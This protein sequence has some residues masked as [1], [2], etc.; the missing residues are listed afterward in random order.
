[1]PPLQKVPGSE[2]EPSGR[3]RSPNFPAISLPEA[4]KRVKAIYDKDGRG[5]VSAGVVL[6]HL[7]YGKKLSGSAGRMISALRQYGLLDDLADN[8]HRV[9]EAAFHILTLSDDSD[10][11]RAALTRCGQKPPVFRDVLAAYPERLPSDSALRDHLITEKK[12]NPASV[13]VFIRA[14]RATVEFACLDPGAHNVPAESPRGEAM[15]ESAR[16]FDPSKDGL[17]QVITQHGAT[18]P[19]ILNLMPSVSREVFSLDAG[20]ALLQ[21]PAAID[22]E[23]VQELEE[24]LNLVIR[25][26]KRRTGVEPKP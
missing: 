5:P 2:S 26:L 24:W 11:R 4:I 13:D 1:M 6:E 7:G 25:K 9:S 8:K 20:E 10:I 22:A 3:S 18:G 15:Q 12:F 21:W 14:F 23:S 17:P 16:P 19:A